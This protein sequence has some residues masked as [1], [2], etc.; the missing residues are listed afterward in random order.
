MESDDIRTMIKILELRAEGGSLTVLGR[1]VGET[2]RYVIIA[3]APSLAEEGAA[4]ETPLATWE[5]VLERLEGYEWRKLRMRF[6][7]PDFAKR[8]EA[9]RRAGTVH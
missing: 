2:W 8:V 3:S 7:H 4:R 6:L 5:E 9:A 1:Q